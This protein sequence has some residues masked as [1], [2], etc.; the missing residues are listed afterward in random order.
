MA[1]KKYIQVKRFDDITQLNSFLEQT[2]PSV[3]GSLSQVN[4]GGN[5]VYIVTW[6]A[7]KDV[8]DAPK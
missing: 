5:V 2:D 7:A 6:Y 3:L 8:P 4:L 1:I